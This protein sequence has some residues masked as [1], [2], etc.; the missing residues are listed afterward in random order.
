ME[1]TYKS[2]PVL[3]IN[4][5]GIYENAKSAV[6]LCKEAGIELTGVVKGTHSY[7]DS[8]VEIANRM[9]DAGCTMIG[10]SRINTIIKM[11][12][13]G[14]TAPILLIRIPM[15]SELE[16]VVEYTQASLNSEIETLVELNKAA[17][18]KGKN[19]KVILMA[20]LGDLREG[21]FKKDELMEAAL[22][23]E[24]ELKNLTLYGIG[25]NLGCY[26]SI[27]PNKENLGK[28]VKLGRE[29]EEKIGRKL[30]IISGG[31]TSTLPMVLAGT[32]PEGINHLRVGE[33]IVI[34]RDL[35]EIWDC[36][37]PMV[38]KDNY[39]IKAQ[40]VELKMKP[41]YPIG[42]IFIDAFGNTPTYIDRGMRKRA[43]LAL[44]KRDIG[45][46]S[47]VTPLIEGATVEGGS[48]DHLILDVTDV[49]EELKVGDIVTFNCYYESM[50]HSTYS[51]SV[52]KV[53][54]ER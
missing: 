28:L 14:V 16:D 49:K 51:S 30:D 21:F 9:V 22:M 33:G 29:I 32:V 31:A 44:G 34:A 20:D 8:Y 24:N 35:P 53:Y 45:G 48:S 27:K 46:L 25:T 4:L 19:H 7:E 38:N 5:K 3:E 12:E 40:I 54:V 23:V 52:T 17:G 6:N 42:E 39:I 26:G 41:T 50:I 18:E 13:M 47:S 15:M 1:N 2:Y 10:D 37:M 36:N 11:R 43:L